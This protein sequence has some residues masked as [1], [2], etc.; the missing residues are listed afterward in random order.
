MPRQAC[1]LLNTPV[2]TGR[3]SV[4]RVFPS[5]AGRLACQTGP[6]WYVERLKPAP[7]MR[8][9]SSSLH[10]SFAH[11]VAASIAP[12]RVGRVGSIIRRHEVE[13]STDPRGPRSGPRYAVSVHR[14]LID[15]IRPARR[16][17]TI[18]PHGGL[19]ALSSLCG[20]ARRPTSG[21]GL[22]AEGRIMPHK[23][24]FPGIHSVRHLIDS[25]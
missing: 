11:L 16:H 12:L 6:S 7:S 15:P 9:S 17:S 13:Y 19:Y 23:N 22:Y 8:R 5:T 21:S 14:H 25:A 1:F 24:V 2:F 20:S 18:S 4:R 3:T 10:P